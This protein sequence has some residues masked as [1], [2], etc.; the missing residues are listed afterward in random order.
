MKLIKRYLCS[1]LV[2]GALILA[3]SF[4]ASVGHAMAGDALEDIKQQGVLTVATEARFAPFEYVE[5]GKIVGYSADIMAHIMKALP[6]V[7]LNRLDLPFQ[8]ILAG[9]EAKKYSY[10]VTSLTA[11]KERY[12]RYALSVPIADATY[13]IVKRTGDTSIKTPMDLGGKIVGVQA[14][15]STLKGVEAL[16]KK[17]AADGNPVKGI[18]TYIDNDEAYADLVAGRVQA[19]ANNLPNLLALQGK[20]PETFEVVAETFGPKRYFVWAGRRDQYSE[21]INAFF[22]DQLRKLNK[23]GILNELQKKWIGGAVELPME[24]PLPN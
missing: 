16:A 18:K 20:R 7:K 24:L 3:A 23:A 19:V 6:G 1:G 9:L 4:A 21:S 13:A 2:T 10:V 12:D 15:S 17:L 8:G 14:G 5:N 22:D 11:T